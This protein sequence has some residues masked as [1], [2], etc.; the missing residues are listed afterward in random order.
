[1]AVKFSDF[2]SSGLNSTG[3]IVGY[4]SD[5]NQNIRIPKSTLDSTYQPT[6][7]S[8]TNIKTINGSSVLGSGDLIV[9][10]GTGG[11]IQAPFQLGSGQIYSN[12]PI[13]ASNATASVSTNLILIMP[14]KPAQTFTT[15]NIFINVSTLG[16][17][18]NARIL[19]YSHSATNGLPDTKIY[20]STNLD[21]STTGVKTA[22]TSQTFTAGTTYWLGVYASGAV[23]LGGVVVSSLIQIGVDSTTAQYTSISR[24]VA[25]GSAPSPWGSTGTQISASFPRIGLTIA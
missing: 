10:G 1:M 25:F 8:G 19:L 3:F 13:G 24:S 6:L 12:I 21:C 22:T 14:F 20:E 23:T 16:A 5:T 9:S 7:I 15:S 18:V 17:G 11:G 2:A 4:D